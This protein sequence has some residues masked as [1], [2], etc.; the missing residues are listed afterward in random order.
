MNG[1]RPQLIM[2]V[3]NGLI[4]PFCGGLIKVVYDTDPASYDIEVS[5]TKCDS[6]WAYPDTETHEAVVMDDEN[7][8]DE[9]ASMQKVP[10]KHQYIPVNNH[11]IC[12]RCGRWE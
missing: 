4:C 8:W 5:C 1:L 10:H 12:V 6:V 7:A 11:S 2:L 9:L 3:G